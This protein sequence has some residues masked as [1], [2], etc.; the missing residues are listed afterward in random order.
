M[1]SQSTNQ[2]GERPCP[3]CPSGQLERIIASRMYEVEGRK[4][5]VDG[6]MPYRCTVCGAHVWPD[7]E[8]Q[9]GRQ[10]LAIKLRKE[11]A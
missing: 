4:I 5:E 6:L 7:A 10:M 2:A 9:R 3:E 8:L 1:S 11:A